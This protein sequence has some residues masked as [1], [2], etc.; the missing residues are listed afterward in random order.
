MSEYQYYEFQAIDRPLSEEEM[1]ILRAFST[2]ARITPTS[3]VNDYEWGNF[4]GN[5]DVWM[6]RFFDAFYY[7]ANWGCRTF[8]LRL[9]SSVLD[10]K[11]ARRYC[12]G[13][14]ASV[15][16][17]KGKTVLTFAVDFDD[18]DEVDM[19]EG[20]LSSLVPLRADLARGDL[21]ALYLGWLYL[22]QCGSVKSGAIEPPVPAGL[23][24]LNA[25]LTS[26]AEFFRLDADLLAAAAMSSEPIGNS[27]LTP[28]EIRAR[29]ARVPAVAKDKLL[30]SLVC[31]EGGV[32]VNPV[33]QEF[34]RKYSL[35]KGRAGATPTGRSAGQLL[36]S[37]KENRHD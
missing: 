8:M 22:V 9:P 19:G 18:Y 7:S 15:R 14:G 5:E 35:G 20:G 10:L 24:E 36:R 3:F 17:K 32:S 23:G 28:K 37:A 27:L 31:G 29:I 26:L 33:L 25:S 11:T 4:R 1:G 34:V 21:R 6:E 30:A 13:E 12:L 16:A 2:R